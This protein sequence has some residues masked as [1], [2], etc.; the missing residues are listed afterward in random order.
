MRRWRPM[1]IA[2]PLAAAMVA[3]VFLWRTRQTPRLVADSSNAA[4][5]AAGSGLYAANCAS[6][7]GERLQGQPGWRDGLRAE[8]PPAPAL[9]ADGFAW[10]NPDR[11]L[12]GMIRHGIATRGMPGFAG[13]LSDDEIWAVVAFIKST[14]PEETRQRHDTLNPQ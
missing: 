5:V 9:D 8:H 2:F 12:V 11:A 3:G 1:M 10:H 13:Q 4:I 6:C 7:H 14:W